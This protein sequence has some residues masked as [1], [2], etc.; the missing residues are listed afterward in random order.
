MELLVDGIKSALDMALC[1]HFSFTPYNE[2]GLDYLINATLFPPELCGH[3]RYT[4]MCI[5]FNAF[6]LVLHRFLWVGTPITF[7]RSPT[8]YHELTALRHITCG[9]TILQ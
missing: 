3:P 9:W 8:A 4:M 6:G 2:G 7:G 5:N 1:Y